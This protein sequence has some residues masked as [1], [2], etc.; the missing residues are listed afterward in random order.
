MML[1]LHTIDVSWGDADE[2]ETREEVEQ[3][4]VSTKA[5]KMNFIKAEILDQ[6]VEQHC[7]PK[8]KDPDWDTPGSAENPRSNTE[9]PGAMTIT[10]DHQTSA[11]QVTTGIDE[12]MD[13][14][15][16][17][18]YEWATTQEAERKMAQNVM[19]ILSDD[20]FVELRST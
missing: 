8:D 9:G 17:D 7:E 5:T 15:R 14:S 20:Q 1:L 6:A 19:P 4:V 16:A 11:L 3:L 10:S 2:A 13:S 18:L 12:R